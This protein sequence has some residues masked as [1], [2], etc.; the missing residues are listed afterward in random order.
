[1]GASLTKARART[2]LCL[3]AVVLL[4]AESGCQSVRPVQD[5]SLSQLRPYTDPQERPRN[6]PGEGWILLRRMSL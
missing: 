6:G 2:V 1:M 5:P 3:A 4:I